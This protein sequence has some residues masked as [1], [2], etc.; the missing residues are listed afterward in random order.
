MHRDQ[1]EGQ[2]KDGQKDRF[3]GTLQEC[4]GLLNPFVGTRSEV[5]T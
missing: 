1:L 2:A 4:S 3:I 5:A